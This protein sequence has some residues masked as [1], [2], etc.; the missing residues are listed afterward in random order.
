[1]AITDFTNQGT[2]APPRLGPDPEHVPVRVLNTLGQTVRV[3]RDR[4]E[5]ELWRAL[6]YGRRPR[7]EVI[8]DE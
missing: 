8:A 2:T 6:L 4:E 1:M 7:Q 5:Y 3:F